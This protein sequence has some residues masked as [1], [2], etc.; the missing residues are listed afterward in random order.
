M[1]T[2]Q[3]MFTVQLGMTMFRGAYS[4][5]WPFIMAAASFITLPVLILFFLGQKHFTQGIALTGLKG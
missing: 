3:E 5:Q 4:T 2:G 1:A